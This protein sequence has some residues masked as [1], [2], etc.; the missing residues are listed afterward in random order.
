MKEEKRVVDS[1]SGH[2]ATY[3]VPLLPCGV[4]LAGSGAPPAAAPERPI[5]FPVQARTLRSNPFCC[6]FP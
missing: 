6:Y 1:E 2:L 5:A 4:I 3:I